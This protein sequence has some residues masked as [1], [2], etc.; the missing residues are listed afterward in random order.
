MKI[1]EEDDTRGEKGGKKWKEE[2]RLKEH[3]TE[4]TKK[5]REGTKSGLKE[6]EIIGGKKC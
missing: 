6:T 5:R 1:T 3:G 4:D 2:K